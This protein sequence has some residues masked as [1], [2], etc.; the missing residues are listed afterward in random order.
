MELEIYKQEE[1]L[2]WVINRWRRN[3]SD[4]WG[5][6]YGTGSFELDDRSD[7]VIAEAGPSPESWVNTG[8]FSGELEDG[9]LYLTCIGPNDGLSFSI[10]LTRKP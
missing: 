4:P 2:I 9:D 1:N 10:S 7:L 3:E 6:E 8:R 5:V